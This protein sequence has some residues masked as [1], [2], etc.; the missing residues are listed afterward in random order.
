MEIKLIIFDVDNTLATPNMPI[1]SPIVKSL[2]KIELKGIRIVL[3]SGKPVSYLSGLARQLR[4]REPILSGENGAIIYYSAKFPPKYDYMMNIY[5]DTY[6]LSLK[7][8]K[9]S[10][11]RAFNNKIWFQPNLINLTVFPR[12][13]SII[14]ELFNHMTRYASSHKGFS[15]RFK[16]YKHND[17]I[18]VIPL[19]VDKGNALRKIMLLE[20]LKK[21]EVIAVGDGVNDIPMFKRA[22]TSFG[23]NFPRAAYN[24]SSIRAAMEFINEFIEKEK[25]YGR[26]KRANTNR[27]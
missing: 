26:R 16:I 23:I 18:E 20:K 22:G 19:T 25:N 2:R 6:V 8:L 13:I 12:N 5:S 9:Q 4:L 27:I 7:K 24:F 3:I 17:S 1:N 14:G 11:I 10:I 21:G 15:N